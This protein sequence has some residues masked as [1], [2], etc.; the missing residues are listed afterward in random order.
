MSTSYK[1]RRTT[2][3][4]ITGHE[5]EQAQ[6]LQD[7]PGGGAPQQAVGGPASDG[8]RDQDRDRDPEPLICCRMSAPADR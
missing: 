4:P 2:V 5:A 1:W 6:R 7:P 3:T 8:A